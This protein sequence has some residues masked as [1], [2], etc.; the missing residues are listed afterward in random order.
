MRKLSNPSGPKLHRVSSGHLLGFTK[1]KER[2]EHLAPIG[3]GLDIA[4]P[5]Y[6]ARNFGDGVVFLYVQ[7][8]R[9]TTASGS[10]GKLE[11]IVWYRNTGSM[12]WSY[13]KTR[14]KAIEGAIL[15]GWK[16]A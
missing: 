2:P 9:G 5:L 6:A 3:Y 16:Y 11:W 14:L 15:D 8:C 1:V 7:K 4:G 13:G 10:G 12:W